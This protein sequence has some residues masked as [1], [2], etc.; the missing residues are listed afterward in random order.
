MSSGTGILNSQVPFRMSKPATNLISH[1]PEAVKTPLKRARDYARFRSVGLRRVHYTGPLEFLGTSYGGYVLPKRELS[2]SSI[3]Y[4]FGA[5]EDISFETELAATLPVDVHIFDP[6]PRSI[7]YVRS[8]IEELSAIDPKRAERLHFYPWGVW[9]SNQQMKFYA[10]RDPAHVSHSL[11]NI[12]HT[13]GHFLADCRRPGSIM[14]SLGH[15]AIALLK[16]NIEGAEYEVMRAIFDDDINPAVVC[17]N[18]DELHTQ[19]DKGARERLCRL[20]RQF[21]NHGY[22]AVSAEAC[23]ATFVRRPTQTQTCRRV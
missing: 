15:A 5:G 10:P 7:E 17:I 13:T 16:L 9:S 19:I 4:S 23:R 21:A 11:L 14:K 18:F 2:A 3:C 6:T 1:L 12:Q 22:D 8:V 20:V